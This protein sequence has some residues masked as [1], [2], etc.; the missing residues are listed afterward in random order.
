MRSALANRPKDH[1]GRI[2]PWF[3]TEKNPDGTWDFT[4]IAPARILEAHKSQVCWVC[5]TPFG[6]NVRVFASGPLSLMT[7]TVAEP[8]MH[9]DCAR[10][11]ATYCPFMT[12]PG[13]QRTFHGETPGFGLARNPAV[14]VLSV[15]RN[16]QYRITPQGILWHLKSVSRAEFYYRGRRATAEE[17][18]NSIDTGLPLL[19]PLL[20]TRADLEA[21]VIMAVGVWQ[22][23]LGSHPPNA[24]ALRRRYLALLASP[25]A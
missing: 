20:K 2:V 15:T 18:E 25:A 22:Y 9:L 8:P 1:R 10:F 23:F 24:D 5:G 14:S 19:V 11:A 4:R 13:Y 16:P 21:I 12:N 3:V 17:L 7:C 6:G